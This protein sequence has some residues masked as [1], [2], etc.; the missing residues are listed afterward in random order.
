MQ[1]KV[2]AFWCGLRIDR[3]CINGVRVVVLLT[4]MYNGFLF[5]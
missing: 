2:E 5:N 3:N 1:R 4:A